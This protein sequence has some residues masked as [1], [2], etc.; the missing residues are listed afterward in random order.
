[1]DFNT[2]DVVVSGDKLI[3]ASEATAA[4]DADTGIVVVKRGT[5]KVKTR[6]YDFVLPFKTPGWKHRI[7][8]Q[9]QYYAGDSGSVSHKNVDQTRTSRLKVLDHYNEPLFIE[10]VDGAGYFSSLNGDLKN[11]LQMDDT[12]SFVQVRSAPIRIRR[13]LQ[14]IGFCTPLEVA[15]AI[16]RTDGSRK[17]VTRILVAEGY[18]KSEV[19]RC[20]R[21]AI[22][23]EFVRED[24]EQLEII[25]GRRPIVRKFILLD[26]IACHGANLTGISESG[27]LLVPGYGPFFGMKL[28]DVLRNAVA[29]APGFAAEF[30]DSALFLGDL[31][32]L[33]EQKFVM[34]S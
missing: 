8:V 5:K 15:H 28:T 30:S 33:E 19:E 2:V 22:G 6:A 13:V 34:S 16:A 3:P 12:H 11:L 25:A 29:L 26:T 14:E 31:Q 24:Y 1:V 18:A 32:W 27:F 23:V 10:Y 21:V 9:A 17:A 20:I 4:D 7:F